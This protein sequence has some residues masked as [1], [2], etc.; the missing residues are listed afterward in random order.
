MTKMALS[1]RSVLSMYLLFLSENFKITH[2]RHLGR[3]IRSGSFCEQIHPSYLQ[4]LN[5]VVLLYMTA[6]KY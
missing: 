3:W 2:E 4:D 6:C 5:V 1:V